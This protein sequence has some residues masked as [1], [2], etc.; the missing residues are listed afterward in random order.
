MSVS[1][2]AYIDIVMQD[3]LQGNGETLRTCFTVKNIEKCIG[4]KT[5][6]FYTSCMYVYIHNFGIYKILNVDFMHAFNMFRF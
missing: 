6:N 2:M 5:L 3:Q 4:M 1:V